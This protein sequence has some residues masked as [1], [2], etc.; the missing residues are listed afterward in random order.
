[1]FVSHQLN[2]YSLRLLLFLFL[3]S[4]VIKKKWLS[5]RDKVG[6]PSGSALFNS[7]VTSF[8]GTIQEFTERW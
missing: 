4:S 7:R 1:M 8:I 3:N 6:D 5:L 2:I